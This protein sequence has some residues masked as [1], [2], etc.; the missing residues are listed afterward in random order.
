MNLLHARLTFITFL[1][2]VLSA[3][4]AF[5]EPNRRLSGYY[6]IEGKLPDGSKIDGFAIGYLYE[7]DHKDP[8]YRVDRSNARKAIDKVKPK[9]LTLKDEN[10]VKQRAK[11]IWKKA[12]EEKCEKIG[13]HFQGQGIGKDICDKIRKIISD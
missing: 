3:S 7:E 12:G 13:K 9:Y 4:F 6:S 2:I 5:S 1:A 8:E 11:L 10:G